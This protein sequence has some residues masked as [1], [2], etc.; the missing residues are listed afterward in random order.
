ME[1][2]LQLP[3]CERRAEESVSGAQGDREER[4]PVSQVTSP[5]EPSTFDIQDLVSL[6]ERN[7]P[8]TD[9][10]MILKAYQFSNDAHKDQKRSSGEPFINHPL[11]VA[12][13]L[14]EFQL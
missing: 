7:N 13:I 4:M 12:R 14:A 6:V 1:Q 3:D 11:G 8:N 5:S 9:K 2:K 10:G